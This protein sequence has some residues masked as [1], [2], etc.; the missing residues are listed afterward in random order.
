MRFRQDAK[1]SAGT[2]ET[3]W[4]HAEHFIRR[5]TG[6]QRPMLTGI[7]SMIFIRVLALGIGAA[8]MA[9]CEVENPETSMARSYTLRMAGECE[10]YVANVRP[11]WEKPSD[12]AEE[13]AHAAIVSMLKACLDLQSDIK[14][15][16]TE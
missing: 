12:A 7:N 1:R 2:P 3:R 5:A 8:L 11:A 16:G 9:S 15:W 10:R 14:T 6:R 13:R 4:P